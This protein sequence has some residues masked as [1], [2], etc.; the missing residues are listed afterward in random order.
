MV[1]LRALLI[2]ICVATATVFASPSTDSTCPIVTLDKGT[3]IG[4]T[5]NGTHGF[6]GIP[7]AHPPSVLHL[8]SAHG[9]L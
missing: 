8:A 1:F 9:P 5:A 6:F 4:T 2:P 7:Y 3:F